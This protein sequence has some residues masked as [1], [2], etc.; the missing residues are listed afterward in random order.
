[1]TEQRS[2]TSDGGLVRVGGVDKVY[3]RGSEAVHVLADLNVDAGE[4]LARDLH[5]AVFQRADVSSEAAIKAR[6]RR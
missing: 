6:R 4:A 1:M 2:G 3:K 5:G